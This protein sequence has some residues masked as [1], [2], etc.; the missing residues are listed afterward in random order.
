VEVATFTHANG[1][2][3]V[4]HFTATVDWGVAGHHADVGIITQDG[5]GTY[6]VSALR[7]VFTEDG[8]FSISVSVSD[9][10]SGANIARNFAGANTFDVAALNSGGFFVPPD[11]GSAVGP[12][13]YVEMV[14]LIV[15][16]YNKDG[17][18]AVPRATLGTFYA[19][20]GVPG[21]GNS[22]SDP[23]IVYDPASGRWF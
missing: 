2:E 6:H 8:T 19:N 14:N 10:D 4:S 23:R 9:N 3:P 13:H 17:S 22:L 12:N 5:G 7:P 15:V 1:V 21:L 16:I 11:Q 18:I 20:A